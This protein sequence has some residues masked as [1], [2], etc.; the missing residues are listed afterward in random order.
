MQ[1]Q[2]ENRIIPGTD[3]LIGS[4]VKAARR[5]AGLTQG[6]LADISGLSRRT[7]SDME[8]GQRRVSA[9]ELMI[10]CWFTRQDIHIDFKE[11]MYLETTS[12]KED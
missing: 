7:I 5:A 9:I 10:L 3:R 11:I 2:T 6:E 12:T 4:K 8:T 1:R